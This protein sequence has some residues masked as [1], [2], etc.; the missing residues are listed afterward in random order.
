[1][2]MR[3]ALVDSVNVSTIWIWSFVIITLVINFAASAA[4][5]GQGVT[6]EEYW[7]QPPAPDYQKDYRQ[8]LLWDDKSGA[9]E[10]LSDTPLEVVSHAT[11]T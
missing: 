9:S 2:S 11:V 10:R 8:S 7:D 3:L 4:G 5:T 6:L 1:M